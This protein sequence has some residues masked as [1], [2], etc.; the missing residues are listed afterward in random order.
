MDHLL[1][2]QCAP[3]HEHAPRPLPLFLEMIRQTSER[4]PEMARA[5]LEG[6][7]K[8]ESAPRVLTRVE[9]PVLAQVGPAVLQ[10]HGGS[11]VPVI[12]VPSLINPPHVLDLDDQVSLASAVAQ[13]G[14]RSLLLDWG[15]AR[16]RADLDVGGHISELLVPLLAKLPEPPALIGYC[17]GGTMAVAAANFAPIERV[18]T[19]AAPWR[20]ANYPEDSCQSLLELWKHA[21]LTAAVLKVL[22]MEVLQAAF[23]SLDPSRTVLKFADFSSLDPAT[24]QA[25]RF[26]ALEDWANEGEPLPLPAA[27]ELI[28]DFFGADLPGTGKWTIKGKVMTDSLSIPMLNCTAANDRITPAQSA[29]HGAVR[30]IASGHV[31]MVVGS[32]RGQ[33]HEALAAFLDPACR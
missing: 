11:G 9:R 29:P 6:L 12:L 33:L 21:E 22:P 28:E 18:V 23:W 20:F 14:R 17:L 24:A 15:A 25:Q 10:D 30:Q 3:Q 1:P 16:E 13:M 27:R 31:G 32:A 8:Y 4:E 2:D 7:V 19:V 26:I 5:A